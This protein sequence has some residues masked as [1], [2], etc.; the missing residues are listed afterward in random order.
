[1]SVMREFVMAR[2]DDGATFVLHLGDHGRAFGFPLFDGVLG[3]AVV[4]Y[5]DDN[6]ASGFA[7]QW[8]NSVDTLVQAEFH[9]V[10][11]LNVEL[12]CQRSVEVAS[13]KLFKNIGG[14]RFGDRL[15]LNLYKP[16]I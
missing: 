7:C 16:V 15:T 9:I 13:A 11:R 2:T 6:F 4:A 3:N 1:M 12:E 5:S 10:N 8:L 14:L